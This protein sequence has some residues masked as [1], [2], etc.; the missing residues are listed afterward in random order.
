MHLP[1]TTLDLF[2]NAKQFFK[3]TDFGFFKHISNLSLIWYI[4]SL[5]Y[6]LYFQSVHYYILIITNLRCDLLYLAKHR[7]TVLI[8]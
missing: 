1:Q 3:K 5:E 7:E 2:V 6:K 4:Y 8:I